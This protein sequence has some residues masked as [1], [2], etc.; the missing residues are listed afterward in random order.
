MIGKMVKVIIDRPLGSFHPKYKGL[1]Y[2]LNY[3]Y[4][5]NVFAEDGEEQDAYVLGINE[6]VVEFTGEVI[7][8]IHRKNDIENKW[9]VAPENVKYTQE[10]IRKAVDFQEQY[11]EIEIEMREKG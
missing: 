6:P 7:A 5:P 4:I 2:L 9:V 8:V 1:Q 11:F 10:E 3:G